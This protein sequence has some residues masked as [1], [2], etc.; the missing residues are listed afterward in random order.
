MFFKLKALIR[1]SFV[2]T[3]TVSLVR[4]IQLFLLDLKR[5]LTR[6]MHGDVAVQEHPPREVRVR[7]EKR[8]LTIL[9]THLP[10]INTMTEQL[11]SETVHILCFHH[12]R[13]MNRI[14]ENGGDIGSIIG[15]AVLA[16]FGASGPTTHKS[17]RAIEEAYAI[18]EVV[19]SLRRDMCDHRA[20]LE[21]ARGALTEVEQR[22][23]YTVQQEIAVG[24]DGG[25]FFYA[26]HGSDARIISKMIGDN[27]NAAAQLQGL[28]SQYR[29]P[30]ICSSN[31]KEEVEAESGAYYFLEI[32]QVM[33]TGTH[34]G[35]RVYWPM[36]NDDLGIA[37]QK[38]IASFEQG[39]KLYYE[40]NWASAYDYFVTCSVLPPVEEFCRR[41]R[42]RICPKD[43]DGIWTLH[44]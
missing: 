27:V 22:L 33:V 4:K 24:I 12:D 21:Q 31:V 37:E 34:T 28:A 18:H 39:L 7:G 38:E 41:T 43:W 5:S 17:L 14:F 40:G 29:V 1:T 44:E 10:S 2:A 42:G 13:L 15:D 6:H 25:E 32:D 9:F 19:A 3:G 36:L 11:E 8:N 26:N 16:A 23:F 20:N 35:K 30:V